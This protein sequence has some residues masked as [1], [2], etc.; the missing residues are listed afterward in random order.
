MRERE[1]ERENNNIRVVVFRERERERERGVWALC[2]K[3]I[4]CPRAD[5]GAWF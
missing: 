1:R 5:V 3:V 4:F 2:T